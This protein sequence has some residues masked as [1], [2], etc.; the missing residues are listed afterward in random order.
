MQV[1][2]NRNYQGIIVIMVRLATRLM[3]WIILPA[4]DCASAAEG[5]VLGLPVTSRSWTRVLV[6]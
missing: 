4:R 2:Y 6:R 1:I 3:G 5:I